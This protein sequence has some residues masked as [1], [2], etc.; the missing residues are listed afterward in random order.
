MMKFAGFSKKDFDTFHIEGL[1]ERMEA[2]QTR[3]QPKF[4]E[5]GGLLTSDLSAML[6]T[7]MF[8]HIAR[9]A[10][11]TVNP[12]KDTWLAICNNKR[13][14]KQHPHFQIGLFDDYVFIWLAFIYE[15]PNKT[16]IAK[17]FLENID[18]VKETVPSDF[19]ISLDHMKKGAVSIEEIQLKQSL[20][21]FRD[22]KKAEFL[23]GKHI[24][25][26]DPI[27]KN[28]EQFIELAKETFEI[29][30]PIYKLAY[31]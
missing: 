22:V 7:E 26:D 20:E 14:Y 30:I 4:N 23:I 11:R 31:E 29:L 1:E 12:P 8:L 21:R 17:N 13:G 19:V 9:H 28:G 24:A 16:K 3:I 2:I 18:L 10:R 6:G 27:L 15:L 5:I 25:A